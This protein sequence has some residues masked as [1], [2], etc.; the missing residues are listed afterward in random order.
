[1]KLYEIYDK[2]VFVSYYLTRAKA[3]RHIERLNK[4]GRDTTSHRIERVVIDRYDVK[5]HLENKLKKPLK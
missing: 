3:V 5:E 4:I 2:D 1:M